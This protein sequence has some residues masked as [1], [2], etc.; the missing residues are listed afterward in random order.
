VTSTSPPG[1]LQDNKYPRQSFND[2]AQYCLTVLYTRVHPLSQGPGLIMMSPTCPLRAALS[3]TSMQCGRSLP[4]SPSQAPPPPA[5]GPASSPA[6]AR[7]APHSGGALLPWHDVDVVCAHQACTQG[8]GLALLQHCVQLRR[9]R[10]LSASLWGCTQSR[11]NN[12]TNGQS[13]ARFVG[14]G[15]TPQATS[16]P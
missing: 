4:Q 9:L 6:L 14:L 16:N 5:K 3:R 12:S 1:P 10:T 11:H 2:P 13:V 8:A 15:G 7:H